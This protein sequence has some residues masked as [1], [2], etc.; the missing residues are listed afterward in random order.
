MK[1][2]V[3]IS[4]FT[5]GGLVVVLIAV[6]A[7]LY[8]NLNKLIK[9]GVE[10]Y[11]PAITKTEVRLSGSEVSLFTG[12]GVL[13][14]IYIGN[15]AGF[16]SASAVEVGQLEVALDTGSITKQTVVIDKVVMTSPTITYEIAGSIDNLHV[17]K[18]NVEETTK[19]E[20][21]VKED[22]PGK[23]V[24]V[25]DFYLN[26]GQV[27]VV[28]ADLGGR[29][30]TIPLPDLHLTNLGTDSGG[31]T[32]GQLAG[33]VLNAI[34]D[35]VLSA[36]DMAMEEIQALAE[37]GIEAVQDGAEAVVE[38]GGEVIESGAEA[39]GDG[40]DAVGGAVEDGVDSVKGLFD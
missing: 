7:V 9:A 31:I 22:K 1:K 38:T 36:A 24:V 34:Y 26:N 30:L 19:K 39:V 8:L 35:N 16:F 3:K 40:V 20:E 18:G 32:P 11:G 5:V 15:P 29:S 37:A 17:L 2:K 28:L 33:L 13:K 10:K 4:L 21:S 25:K 14:G 23:K 6:V 12:R 27:K